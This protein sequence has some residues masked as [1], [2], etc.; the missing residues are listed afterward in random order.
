[1]SAN[2]FPEVKAF[3]RKFHKNIRVQKNGFL[4]YRKEMK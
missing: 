2:M 3:I 1:M 4:D